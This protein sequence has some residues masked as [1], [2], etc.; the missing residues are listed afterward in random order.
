MSPEEAV[1]AYHG[2]L[3]KLHIKPYRSLNDDLQI[4]NPSVSY[5]ATPGTVDV[6]Q[7]IK[8]E[9]Q[10]LPVNAD[11]SLDFKKMTSKQKLAYNRE[12]LKYGA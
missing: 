5:G 6:L 11:G 1:F 8:S 10:A 7:S 12:K 3:Q 9:P 2:V 4:T